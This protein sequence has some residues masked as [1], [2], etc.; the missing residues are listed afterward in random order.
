VNDPVCIPPGAL[1]L[2]G[3]MNWKPPAV[4]IIKRPSGSCTG[5]ICSCITPSPPPYSGAIA[6]PP[7]C[8][9]RAINSSNEGIGLPLL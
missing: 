7:D 5:I 8:M 2:L 4:G 1:L 6:P 3:S 9:Y